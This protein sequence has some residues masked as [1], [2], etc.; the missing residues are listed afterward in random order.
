MS[1]ALNEIHFVWDPCCIVSL[2][3]S[4]VVLT[5]LIIADG[6]LMRNWKDYDLE[7]GINGTGEVDMLMNGELVGLCVREFYDI[8]VKMGYL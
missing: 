3:V 8:S 6:L 2:V 5:C 1:E 4:C 7:S